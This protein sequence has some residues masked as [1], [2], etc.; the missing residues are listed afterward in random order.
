MM[1]VL[2]PSTNVFLFFLNLH[3]LFW[4]IGNAILSSAHLSGYTTNAH[5]AAIGAAG[6]GIAFLLVI[7]LHGIIISAVTKDHSHVVASYFSVLSLPLPSQGSLVVLYF[8]I[9]TLIS[10]A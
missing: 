9:S 6:G 7:G 10:V 2:L 5:A 1:F 8:A 3:D 4:V